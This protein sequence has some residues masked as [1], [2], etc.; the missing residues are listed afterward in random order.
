[1]S[2]ASMRHRH[3]LTLT[4]IALLWVRQVRLERRV[5]RLERELCDGLELLSA[6]LE[7]ASDSVRRWGETPVRQ[8]NRAV[9]R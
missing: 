9:R 7:C 3:L 6:E 5:A 8:V 2:E 1:M 4:P